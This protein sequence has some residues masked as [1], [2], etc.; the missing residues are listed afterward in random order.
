[1]QHIYFTNVKKYYYRFK[2]YWKKKYK[3][4]TSKLESQIKEQIK[5]LEKLKLRIKEIE[6]EDYYYQL[7]LKER[8]ERIKEFKE[9]NLLVFYKINQRFRKD[10]RRI[11]EDI[12]SLSDVLNAAASDGIPGNVSSVQN[13]WLDD[14]IQ[15][16]AV[17]IKENRI[18]NDYLSIYQ[19]E[20]IA[21]R[22][23]SPVLDT[24]TGKFILNEAAVKMLGLESPVGKVINVYNHLDTVIGVVKDFHYESSIF[25]YL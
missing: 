2:F 11:K 7:W 10:F 14:D 4:D 8:E 21:G 5:E 3:E 22:D 24:D 20:L 16:N 15:D 6:S 23:F 19:M 1:M 25:Q 13:I 12:L 17:M 18:R 9:N